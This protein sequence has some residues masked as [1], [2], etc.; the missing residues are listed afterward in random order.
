MHV[1]IL[2]IPSYGVPEKLD[3][4]NENHSVIDS[5]VISARYTLSKTVVKYEKLFMATN[6]ILFM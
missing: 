2:K 3:F 5:F 4:V 6:T 1:S